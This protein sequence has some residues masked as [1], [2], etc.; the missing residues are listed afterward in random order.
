MKI[1]EFD[2]TLTIYA[3][4]ENDALFGY[5]QITKNM[6]CKESYCSDYREVG[7]LE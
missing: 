4:D 2:T 6:W 3:E 7:E 5:E 1:Y